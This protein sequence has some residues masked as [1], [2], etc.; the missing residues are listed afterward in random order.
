MRRRQVT[1][2]T[3][4]VALGILSFGYAIRADV[5]K[6]SDSYQQLNNHLESV[7]DADQGPRGRCC[8]GGR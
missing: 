1:L 7:D 5:S 3:V 2:V 8:R 6:R 4:V